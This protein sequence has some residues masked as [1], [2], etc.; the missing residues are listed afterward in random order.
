MRF[1]L[2][3]LMA[4]S[5]AASL[6]LFAGAPRVHGE[7]ILQFG[8]SPLATVS[9]TNPT[10]STTAINIANEAIQITSI[11]GNTVTINAVLTLSANSI[12]AATIT[13]GQI[14][15]NFS[16]SFSITNGGSTNYLSGTFSDLTFGQ[17]GGST[18]T[19]SANQPHSTLSFTS[20]F[21]PAFP[22]GTP[23]GANFTFTSVTP[24][25]HTNGSG[26]T[27]TIA[28]FTG[29]TSGNMS[30]TAAV[31]EPSTMAIAGL[32]ALGMIGYGLRRRKALGA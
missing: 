27:E 3:T 32:G 25:L 14:A 7:T 30:A 29:S 15:Q 5:L 22:L 11:G 28:A 18:A 26:S 2:P 8:G 9:V 4:A 16:G 13:S 20:N 31:P 19:L 1:R 17:D 6:L 24:L 10:A 21:T 23:T 12:G